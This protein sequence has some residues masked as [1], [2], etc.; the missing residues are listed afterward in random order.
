MIITKLIIEEYQ[1]MYLTSIFY[2]EPLEDL[3]VTGVSKERNRIA[4]RE[5]VIA[6]QTASRAGTDRHKYMKGLMGSSVK[7]ERHDE[8]NF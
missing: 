4:H 7:R 1:V 6:S 8:I 5:P 2:I 3:P